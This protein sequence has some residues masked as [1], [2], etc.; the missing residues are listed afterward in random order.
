VLRPFHAAARAGQ[1]EVI[2]IRP[3]ADAKTLFERREILIELSEKPDVISEI[4][5]IDDSLCG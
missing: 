5:Q 3:D 2:A 1:Q 4:A